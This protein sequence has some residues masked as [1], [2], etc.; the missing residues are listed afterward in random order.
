MDRLTRE[1]IVDQLD[2][3]IYKLKWYSTEAIPSEGWIK[4]I[5]IGLQMT[6]KQL[7]HRLGI[8]TQGAKG[9]ERRETEGALTLGKMN[10]IAKAMDM[11]FVYGFVPNSGSLKKLI[12]KQAT[13][14][15]TK[16]VMQ[17]STYMA[18]EDQKVSEQRIKKAIKERTEE[19]M[20]QMPKHLWD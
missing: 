12:E 10:E 16:I 20:I 11:K 4:G 17:T 1:L 15:A 14:L 2:N 19:L 7:G 8:T 5:R 13:E 3:K 6:L 9:I 18:L